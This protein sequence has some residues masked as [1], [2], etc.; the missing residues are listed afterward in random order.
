MWDVPDD[1]YSNPDI[2]N[3]LDPAAAGIQGGCQPFED[4]RDAALSLL[5]RMYF[6]YDRMAIIS[7]ARNAVV[8]QAVTVIVEAVAG[9]AGGGDVARAVIVRRIELGTGFERCSVHRGVAVTARAFTLASRRACQ[10]ADSQ[11]GFQSTPRR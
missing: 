7:F 1:Y 4:V 9:L 2:C 8:H 10:R 6:P 11:P 3:D 5:S